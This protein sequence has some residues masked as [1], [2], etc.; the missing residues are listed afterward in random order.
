MNDL[1]ARR[2]TL[3]PCRGHSFEAVELAIRNIV[4]G[5][6]PYHFMATHHF[7]LADVDLAIRSLGGEGAPGAIHVTVIPWEAS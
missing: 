1:L 2:L 3:R 5:R 6:F 7:G 4:S